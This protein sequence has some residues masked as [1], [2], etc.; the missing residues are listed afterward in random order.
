MNDVDK[1]IASVIA[2]AHLSISLGH[3]RS[4]YKLQIYY[5]F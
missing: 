5:N 4:D 3:F 1:V 2:T